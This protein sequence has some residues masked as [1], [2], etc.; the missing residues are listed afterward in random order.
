MLSVGYDIGYDTTETKILYTDLPTKA[1]RHIP[2][3]RIF[4]RIDFIKTENVLYLSNL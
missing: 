4:K 3:N 1:I 2:A